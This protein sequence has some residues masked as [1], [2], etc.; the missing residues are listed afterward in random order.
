MMLQ[1]NIAKHDDLLPLALTEPAVGIFSDFFQ[2][3]LEG[4]ANQRSELP[5][6]T[7]SP[8]VLLSGAFPASL[9]VLFQRST[10]RG[11]LEAQR[12]LHS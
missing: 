10:A 1:Q 8:F 11:I 9:R 2:L 6:S 12:S 4:K 7:T 5:T 3:H